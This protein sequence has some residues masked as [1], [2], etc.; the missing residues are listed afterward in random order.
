[1]PG[2]HLLVIGATGLVGRAIVRRAA[3]RGAVDEVVAMVRRDPG[4]RPSTRV[5]YRVVDFDRLDG[6]DDAFAVDAVLCALGTTAR[7]T[8][9]PADYRRIE[10]EI[11]LE[12][13]RRAQAAGATRF[14][15]VSS[16]GA[17]PTS[18]ATYLRQKGELEQALEA[19]GWERLVIARPSVIAGRRSEFRRSERIGLLVGQ[20][21]PLRYRPIAAERIATEL[22]SA[23]IQAGPAVEVLDNIT[24]H[25]GI[26]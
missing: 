22:V 12:V 18:R 26:G 24:L 11:P 5:S 13:A 4:A 21:A 20:V 10:V 2:L 25:R 14:G 3:E 15:L 8:P 7:Q 6:L 19:M 16:V 1:M 9:D 17:D 23:V